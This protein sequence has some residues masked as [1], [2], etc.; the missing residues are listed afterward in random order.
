LLLLFVSVAMAVGPG[1]AA[2][3]RSVVVALREASG[4]PVGGVAEVAGATFVH[5]HERARSGES[6]HRLTVGMM[7]ALLGVGL[8]AG[9]IMARRYFLVAE[10]IRVK[11]SSFGRATAAPRRCYPLEGVV[12]G[13]PS[14]VVV[15][16]LAG[17][18]AGC[19]V[20]RVAARVLRAHGRWKT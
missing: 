15:V 17:G 7:V 4:L 8:P 1:V 3:S 18:A 9:G 13:A 12:F 19:A 20:V 14:L 6:S 16:E 5:A 2:A 10:A 11:T